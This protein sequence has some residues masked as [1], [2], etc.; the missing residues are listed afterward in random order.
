[1]VRITP[2]SVTSSRE[3]THCAETYYSEDWLEF[4]PDVVLHFV[5][6]LEKQNTQL[7]GFT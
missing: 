7:V 1:M 3:E 5:M 6:S 4:A 2:L